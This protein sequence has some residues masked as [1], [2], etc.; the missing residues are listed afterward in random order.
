[1][2]TTI[3]RAGRIVIPK[4]LREA[5]GLAAGVEVEVELRDGRIELEP[6][7]APMRERRVGPMLVFE[8]VAEAPALTAE[9]V[10][11]IL[12]RLRR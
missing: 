12:E 1:M 3:D 4:P 10:R 9:D 11:D 8:P 5:A 7:S 2:R 6:A